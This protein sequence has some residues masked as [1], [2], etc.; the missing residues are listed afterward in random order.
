MKKPLTHAML[1][2]L[3]IC[4]FGL[5]AQS[6]AGAYTSLTLGSGPD[7]YRSYE[8]Y[9]DADLFELPLSLNL[10]HFL[11]RSTGVKDTT[12]TGIGLVWDATD[13][14]SLNVRH[15][16][17]DDGILRITGNAG[18]IALSFGKT[19]RSTFDLGYGVND[20]EP[21]VHPVNVNS[22]IL[23]QKQYTAGFR[24]DLAETFTVHVSHDEYRYS[25]DPTAI[26]IL[27]ILRS[28]NTSQAA[29]TLLGF[30]DRG[31]MLGMQWLPAER[32]TLDISSSRTVTLLDQVQKSIRL[33]LD[34]QVNDSLNIAAAVTRSS[35]TALIRPS[36][37]QT[38]LEATQ[39]N[40]PELTLGVTF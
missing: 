19:L 17:T 9:A 2:L 8:V 27:L 40:Y 21:S 28:R 23:E 31:T 1:S 6:R 10:D 36:T 11:G 25:R 13:A 15:S 35:S 3:S 4:L 34:Y 37:G 24:Q 32:L 16:V 12:Q 30:P 38:V 33:G 20:Y 14:L 26:A 5:P 18:G 29:Y 7:G 39:G 22:N